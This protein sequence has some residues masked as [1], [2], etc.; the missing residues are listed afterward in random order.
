[1]AEAFSSCNSLALENKLITHDPGSASV[2]VKIK[3]LLPATSRIENSYT[4]TH[5]S[6]AQFIRLSDESLASSKVCFSCADEGEADGRLVVEIKVIDKKLTLKQPQ[7][8]I[9]Q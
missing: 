6:R 9:E 3:T 8:M 4:Q 7:L 5:R 2:T 1:M